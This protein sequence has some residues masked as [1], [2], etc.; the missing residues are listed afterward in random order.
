MHSRF[1]LIV[2]VILSTVLLAALACQGDSGS[3]NSTTTA[4]SGKR[5]NASVSGSVTYRE[6]LALTPRARLEVQLRDTSYQD[7]ASD[8]IAEQVIENP[9]QVPIKFKVEYNRDDVDDRNTYSLQA[10]IVEADG[11]LA[12]INDTAYDV[13]TRGNPSKVGMLL[14]MVEPPPPRD[15]EE[16]VDPHEWVEVPYPIVG[17]EMLPPNAGLYLKVFYQQSNLENCS[18]PGSKSVEVDG[19]DILIFLTHYVPPPTT[20]AA[21]CEDEI[22]ELDDIIDLTGMLVQGETYRVVVNGTETL[23]FVA[24]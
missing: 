1:A 24:R 10:R 18:R 2:F 5:P 4:T 17:A 19:N 7:A 3:S 12:F 21:P 22:V 20:W 14:V 11:R 23:T 6:R 9:G 13:I 15:G 16:A 8:L